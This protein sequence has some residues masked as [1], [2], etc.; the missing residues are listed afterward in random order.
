MSF[1]LQT[2]SYATV[3]SLGNLIGSLENGVTDFSDSYE[4]HNLDEPAIL[5]GGGFVVGES[6]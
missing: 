2:P 3:K 5:L 4:H 6:K 1:A